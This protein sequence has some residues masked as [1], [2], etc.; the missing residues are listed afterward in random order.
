M[1]SNRKA[2]LLTDDNA[3]YA[4]VVGGLVALLV[5]IIVSILVYF[6]V[7]EDLCPTTVTEYFTGY[8]RPTWDGA[9]SGGSNASYQNITLQYA[10]YSET[11]ETITL[12]CWNG[13]GTGR[14]TSQ[15]PKVIDAGSKRVTIQANDVTLGYGNPAAYT[16]INVTYTTKV[17]TERAKVDTTSST[18]FNLLPIIAIVTIGGIMIALVMGFGKGG[19][20]V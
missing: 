10:P 12:V 14:C 2:K 17:G 19:K 18:V 1:K 4:A 7:N 13:S 3:E 20:K 15:P 6:S 8:T 16:Q 9:A 11:N 5:T